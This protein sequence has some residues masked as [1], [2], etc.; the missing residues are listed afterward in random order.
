M[1]MWPWDFL[2]RVIHIPNPY[3]A[4]GMNPIYPNISWDTLGVGGGAYERDEEGDV[5]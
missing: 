4:S 2:L 5:G 1:E 3:I